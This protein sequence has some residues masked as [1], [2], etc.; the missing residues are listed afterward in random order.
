MGNGYTAQVFLEA[1][2][3]TGGIV[4]AIARRKLADGIVAWV[5][6]EDAERVRNGEQNN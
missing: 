6:R 5:R 1:I 4:S 2:P 3:G